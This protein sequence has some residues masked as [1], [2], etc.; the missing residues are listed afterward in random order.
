MRGSATGAQSNVTCR[1]HG[2]GGGAPAG[3]LGRD[4]LAARGEYLA[5]MIERF[6]PR[7]VAWPTVVVTLPSLTLYDQIAIN[8]GEAL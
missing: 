7:D 5:A 2:A 4:R 1:M 8:A 3:R 6:R